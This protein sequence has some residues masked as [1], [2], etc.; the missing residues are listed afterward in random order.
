MDIRATTAPGRSAAYCKPPVN[1]M[2]GE[3]KG[4]T[5]ALT[6]VRDEVSLSSDVQKIITKRDTPID[7]AASIDID[8]AD[9]PGSTS[10]TFPS[11]AEVFGKITQDYTGVIRA[12]Y[13]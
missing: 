6:H 2:Q 5:A 10:T 4:D 12:H 9:R 8:S 1:G 3:K 11:F 7:S 13:A